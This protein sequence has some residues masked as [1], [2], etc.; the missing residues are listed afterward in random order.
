MKPGQVAALETAYSPYLSNSEE[1]VNKFGEAYRSLAGA[2]ALSRVVGTNYA[3][4]SKEQAFEIAV[5]KAQ[6]FAKTHQSKTFEAMD[7]AMGFSQLGISA[8]DLS[9]LKR[10]RTLTIEDAEDNANAQSKALN[11]SKSSAEKMSKLSVTMAQ[12]QI[13]MS[14]DLART[15]AKGAP[16]VG[17]AIKNLAGAI[18]KGVNLIDNAI[19]G[20]LPKHGALGVVSKVYHYLSGPSSPLGKARLDMQAAKGIM[21]R[22]EG[23]SRYAAA[24]AQ[25]EKDKKAYEAL[26][27]PK[28]WAKQIHNSMD[29]EP[30]AA[31]AKRF[32]NSPVPL[33]LTKK[34]SNASVQTKQIKNNPVQKNLAKK[35]TITKVVEPK[36]V[37][38]KQIKNNPVSDSNSPIIGVYHNPNG[39]EYD[40]FKSPAAEYKYAAKIVR[41]YGKYNTLGNILSTYE[42]S[43]PSAGIM[44]AARGVMGPGYH[45]GQKLDLS[46]PETMAHVLTAIRIT[47]QPHQRSTEQILESIL[48]VLKDSRAPVVHVHVADQKAKPNPAGRV[49][50]AVHAAAAG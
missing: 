22:S 13:Q 27:P 31:Q 18:N 50:M 28:N 43:K 21:E 17:I 19:E 35:T 36:I 25:Y 12:A 23:T 10:T 2:S 42:G 7:Q 34:P 16:I 37:Q 29:I 46:N 14:T 44:E 4:M 15:M 26:L 9:I 39:Q 24:K 20:K 49:H 1:T 47:E 48:A 32:K 30:T 11:F 3:Q 33:L 45:P 8:A 41:G 40:I 5:S 38:T 6:Q